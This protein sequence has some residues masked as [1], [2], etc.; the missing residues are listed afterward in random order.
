MCS[1]Y[2][3]SK[4]TRFVVRGRVS[5][6]LFVLLARLLLKVLT[7]CVCLLIKDNMNAFGVFLELCFTSCIARAF[8]TTKHKERFSV[9]K[10]ISI[11]TN[12]KSCLPLIPAT[13][14]LFH[15]NSLAPSLSVS[16]PF[17]KLEWKWCL[18]HVG[19]L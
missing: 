18:V 1:E 3:K 9:G 17:I 4:K 15:L 6:A 7:I 13:S 10:T 2:I 5:R 12:L 11:D 16:L 14:L 19:D 8:F